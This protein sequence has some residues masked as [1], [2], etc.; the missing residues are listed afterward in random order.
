MNPTFRMFL[1]GMLLTE[2]V[3]ALIGMGVGAWRGSSWIGGR[4]EA[5]QHNLLQPLA[6]K[7]D[8]ATLA[9]IPAH[10]TRD[11]SPEYRDIV[12]QLNAD[13]KQFFARG[14]GTLSVLV[15]VGDRLDVV[16]D[17]MND[18]TGTN[19]GSQDAVVKQALSGAGSYT[20]RPVDRNPGGPT[21]SAYAPIR[22]TSGK[23]TYVLALDLDATAYKEAQSVWNS[24]LLAA[25]L[26][27][28][29]LTFVVPCVLAA[30]YVD[31]IEFL[32]K[33]ETATHTYKVEKDK[34]QQA[35]DAKWETLTP[36]EREIV[37]CV[38]KGM[39]NKEIAAQLVISGETVKKHL[40]NVFAKL[41]I[42]NRTELALYAVEKGAM[43]VALSLEP[44]PAP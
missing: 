1:V 13:S 30:S 24:A 6:Q 2:I 38:G 41:A 7:L 17:E 34:E 32:K 14:G 44:P 43:G 37:L 28:L 21:L 42:R 8:A 4:M 33:I 10:A 3:A 25:V 35:V 20:S 23:T 36:R 5:Y 31:P 40:Q 9:R 18:A 19:A 12:N 29:V 27:V 26:P 22:D 16:V 11:S 15:P 39:T